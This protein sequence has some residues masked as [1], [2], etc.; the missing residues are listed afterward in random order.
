MVYVSFSFESILNRAHSHSL[1]PERG[2]LN[3]TPER[4]QSQ[5]AFSAA[6]PAF[7]I[8]LDTK[9][10]AFDLHLAFCI[11][12]F[13]GHS[14]FQFF[15]RKRPTRRFK[16]SLGPNLYLLDSELTRFKILPSRG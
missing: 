6:L 1:M 10:F 8:C 3:L 5:T 4:G 9:H 11:D 15:A 7:C 14:V 12:I 2:Y 16:D 13:A